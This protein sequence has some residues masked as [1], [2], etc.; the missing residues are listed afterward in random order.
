MCSL[1]SI[2]LKRCQAQ[3]AQKHI[4]W[5]WGRLCLPYV[6][7]SLNFRSED[8]IQAAMLSSRSFSGTAI[9]FEKLII[10]ESIQ[11]QIPS[12]SSLVE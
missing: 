2:Y 3:K 11:I 4:S 6:S 12:I 1:V 10:K 7:Y 8:G 5:N 9:W